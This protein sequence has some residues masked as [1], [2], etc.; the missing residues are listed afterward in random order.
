[1]DSLGHAAQNCE[2]ALVRTDI[3]G[4]AEPPQV[5]IEIAFGPANELFERISA[6][7]FD[8]AIGIVRRGHRGYF[9]RESRRQK[10]VK[11]AHGCILPRFVGVE[12][13][14]NLFNIA[15]ENAGMV[16][17]ESRSLGR[18]DILD[19][20]HEAG[21]QVKLAF[22]H[23]GIFRV[24]QRAFGFVEPEENFALREDW[25]FG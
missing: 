10:A 24:Q 11:S 13:E 8:V 9:D 19:A 21:D 16:G 12:T 2:A 7:C 18:D 20:G 23:N 25:C 3:V 1:V 22:A 14:H 15:F 17:S 6:E 5:E 4:G